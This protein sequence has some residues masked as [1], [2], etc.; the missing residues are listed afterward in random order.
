MTQSRVP[1]IR[2][3]C[4]LL[5]VVVTVVRVV[6]D[7][8]DAVKH[9]DPAVVTI[10]AGEWS[11]SGFIVS[12][13]G[14]IVTNWHVIEDADEG[15]ISVKLLD[16]KT[17]PATVHANAD[18]RDLA[19]LKVD[20][21]SLPVVQFAASDELASGQ[22]VAAIGAP[23]GFEH[24][25]TSGVVSST[26]R[27][28]DEQEFIQIDAAINKGSSGG[29]VINEDGQVV[30]VAVIGFTDADNVAL[31]IPSTDVMRFL[32]EKDV[33]FTA[34]LGAT[35][36]DEA[37]QDE[38][39]EG[40]TDGPEAGAEASPSD[41]ETD[42]QEEEEEPEPRSGFVLFRPWIFW[43][44]IISFFVSAIVALIVSLTMGRRGPSPAAVIP[45]HQPVPGAA[46]VAPPPVRPAVQEDLSDIDIDLH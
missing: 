13:D 41:E 7:V 37:E 17:L 25:V 16:E 46:P 42:D 30:G 27:K 31:A 23:L 39:A 2:M 28:I 26:S 1:G 34:A 43:P 38:E 36:P 44:V 11:G 18:K 33:P 29:P 12:S 40:T 5:L 21:S 10:T 19:V 14:Y 4:M 8:P 9:V 15:S 45:A 6:A 20:S 24:S 3:A 35:P 32:R 22:K